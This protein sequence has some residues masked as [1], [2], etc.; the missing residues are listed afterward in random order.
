MPGRSEGRAQAVAAKAVAAKAVA[1]KAAAPM[2]SYGMTVHDAA[3]SKASVRIALDRV[4]SPPG[5]LHWCRTLAV[6]AKAGMHQDIHIGRVQRINS[7]AAT[8][9]NL[10]QTSR[11]RQKETLLAEW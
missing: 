6:A 5:K 2:R 7:S 4:I 9:G 10:I 1:A 8:L 3:H 11:R